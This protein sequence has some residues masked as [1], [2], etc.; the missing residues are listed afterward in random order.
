MS[1][2]LSIDL[3]FF[4]RKHPTED[5]RFSPVQGLAVDVDVVDC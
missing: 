5:G 4:H 2:F 3:F 1:F